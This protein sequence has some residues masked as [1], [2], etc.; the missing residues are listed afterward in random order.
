M[1]NLKMSFVA[2]LEI[3]QWNQIYKSVIVVSLEKITNTCFL[4]NI[5]EVYLCESNQLF[6]TF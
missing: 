2:Q 1:R 3:F 5:K 6:L 4:Q